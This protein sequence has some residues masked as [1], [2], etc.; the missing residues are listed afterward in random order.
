[1]KV[2]VWKFLGLI[3]IAIFALSTAH[4]VYAIGVV[5]TIPVGK[6]G[7]SPPY[8]YGLAYDSSK[9]EIFVTNE[10]A[11]YAPGTVS[12][13]SDSTNAVVANITLGNGAG[14]GVAY[15][16]AY[17]SGKGEIFV[18]NAGVNA[19]SVISDTTNAV[20]A[21]ITVGLTPEELA[22]DSSTSEIFVTN[23]VDGTVSIISDSNN[24]VVT[25]VTV[26]S[27]PFAVAYDSGKNETFVT[28]AAD[29]TVSV[30]SY[31]AVPEFSN[32]GLILAMAAM[33]AVT[34]CAVGLTVRKRKKS[35]THYFENQRSRI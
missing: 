19:V 14:R 3:L 10:G 13:I 6:P 26:G 32:A 21:N 7:A 4:S 23:T 35:S 11:N 33:A 20:V 18:T 34:I 27:G 12:V 2:K 29:S 22:Y 8:D 17:D 31:S 25:N 24:T 15:G 16:V 5:A 1:M 28:N 9:G 30:I